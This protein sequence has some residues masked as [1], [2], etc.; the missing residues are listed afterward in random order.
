MGGQGGGRAVLC[1]LVHDALQLLLPGDHKHLHAHRR[2][3]RR[4]ATPRVR[5]GLQAAQRKPCGR[6]QEEQS[7]ESARHCVGASNLGTS[8]WRPWLPCF[9]A[10]AC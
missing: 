3:T 1:S 6:G 10:G 4:C 2:S 7:G 9:S 8:R 5:R